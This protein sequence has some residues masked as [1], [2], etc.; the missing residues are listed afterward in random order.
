MRLVSKARFAEVSGVT[1]GAVTKACQGVLFP[2]MQGKSIDLDHACVVAYLKRR[3]IDSSEIPD[4][5]PRKPVGAGIKKER[6]K[7]LS[8]TVAEGDVPL[9][10]EAVADMTLRDI[11]AKYGTDARFIDW[12]N[13]VQK[14]E[15]IDEKRIKNAK[16]RG[17]L[18]SR[19]LVEVG[20]ID[21]FNAAHLRLLK[22]GAKS[23]V[24][25]VIA[26]HKSGASINETEN[27]VSDILTSFI[28]PVKAKVARSLR[29]SE[30]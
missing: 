6:K 26:K 8:I 25:G 21:V 27:Y 9:E 5:K 18:V 28:R 11:V 12:L 30:E 23:I 2:A 10:M 19:R 16:A 3:G 20:V 17:E 22:D 7:G 29:E 1:P 24:G 15:G 4:V 13:A 14:L